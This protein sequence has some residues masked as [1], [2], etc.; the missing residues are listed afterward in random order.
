MQFSD[1]I[2]NPKQNFSVVDMENQNDETKDPKFKRQLDLE[3]CGLVK[4]GWSYLQSM[5][6][7]MN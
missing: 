2:R 4:Q 5:T 3:D 6:L 1:V 7:D